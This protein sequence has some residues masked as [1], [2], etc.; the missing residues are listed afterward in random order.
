M[1]GI[2]WRIMF[3][4]VIDLVFV[5]KNKHQHNIRPKVQTDH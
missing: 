5:S 2:E 3:E 4:L 1:S